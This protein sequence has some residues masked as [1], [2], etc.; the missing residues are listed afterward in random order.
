[1]GDAI[2]DRESSKGASTSGAARRILHISGGASHTV[3]VLCN[4]LSASVIVSLSLT[5]IYHERYN[6]YLILCWTQ[7]AQ[8]S[9]ETE[10]V[11]VAGASHKVGHLNILSLS[12]THSCRN[13]RERCT[14]VVYVFWYRTVEV[15]GE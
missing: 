4:S 2:G 14:S 5:Q 11:S 3:A 9:E 8:N 15:S 12:L 7:N 1:M 6:Q 13:I 10:L